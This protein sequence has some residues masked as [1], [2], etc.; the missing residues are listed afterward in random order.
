MCVCCVWCVYVVWCVCVVCVCGVCGVC[1]VHV[2][3]VCMCMHVYM[4]CVHM[5]CVYVYVCGVCA[6]MCVN[7]CV[8]A[9]PLHLLKSNR[10]LDSTAHY[11]SNFVSQISPLKESK[12]RPVLNLNTHFKTVLDNGLSRHGVWE[13]RERGLL[14][15]HIY[16]YS[17]VI[18]SVTMV[19]LTFPSL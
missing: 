16:V 7:A 19:T 4:W 14:P 1:G 13:G 15:P 2:V 8:N 17:M 3:C 11:V 12:L 9:Y 10:M 5:W 6:C 18:Y